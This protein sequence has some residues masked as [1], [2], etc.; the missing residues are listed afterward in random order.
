MRI[1]ITGHQR[2]SDPSSW[3]WVKRE[4]LA[5]AEKSPRPLIAVS[6]LAIGADQLFAEL[7]LQNG[8]TLEAVIP[9]EGYEKTFT[10]DVD[11]DSYQSLLGRSSRVEV[12]PKTDSDEEAY[13]GAGRRVVDLCELLVAVWD[14]KPAAGLGGTGDVVEYAHKIQ[15]NVVHLNPTTRRI[16]EK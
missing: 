16:L 3:E 1:G 12:L 5:L 9:F 7:V 8:G 6:S 4:M 14:G 10:D 2:L 13:L 11:K 15:R